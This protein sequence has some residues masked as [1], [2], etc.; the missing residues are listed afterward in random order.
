MPQAMRDLA[1]LGAK[2]CILKNS[3]T[4]SVMLYN[5][6]RLALAALGVLIKI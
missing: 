6:T 5:N 3:L 2:R 4:F 1:V